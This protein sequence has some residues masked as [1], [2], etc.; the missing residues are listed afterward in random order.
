MS[1]WLPG[2]SSQ[3]SFSHQSFDL[4][5]GAASSLLIWTSF[6]KL[7]RT[8]GVSRVSGS[9]RSSR[10]PRPRLLVRRRRS[11]ALGGDGAREGQCSRRESRSRLCMRRC[12]VGD[13]RED[14]AVR[15]DRSE[16][17]DARWRERPRSVLD[18]YSSARADLTAVD[19][20]W[21]RSRVR[22]LIISGPGDGELAVGEPTPSTVICILSWELVLALVVEI[23]SFVYSTIVCVIDVALLGL[24]SEGA[25][26]SW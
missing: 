24:I 16:G 20:E 8:S 1:S 10:K 2:L 25:V 13:M 21:L 14:D 26:S 5:A 6:R 19:L 7:D 9:S 15:E 22:P 12:R 23:M 4:T 11:P 18:S 3:A 17:E